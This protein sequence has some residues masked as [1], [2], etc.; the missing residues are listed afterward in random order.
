MVMC[1]CLLVCTLVQRLLRQ[2]LLQKGESVVHQVGKLAQRPTVRWAFQ[3]FDEVGP[4][5]A[6]EPDR[7]SY[8]ETV[9]DLSPEEE[10]S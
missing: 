10:K 7:L 8:E 5:L 1:L 4:S 6:R 9:V 2:Q 3:E